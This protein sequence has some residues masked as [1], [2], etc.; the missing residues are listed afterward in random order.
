MV[1]NAYLGFVSEVSVVCLRL[2]NKDP[3]FGVGNGA[4]IMRHGFS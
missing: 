4:R 2:Q 1:A 3:S